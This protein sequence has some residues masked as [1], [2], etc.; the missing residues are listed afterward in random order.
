MDPQKAR[1]WRPEPSIMDY[2]TRDAVI[3]ALGLGCNV[4]DDLQYLYEN[5][6]D[7][8]VF[9]T[10]VVRPGL[11]SISLDG[12]PGIAFDLQNILH[13]EQYIELINPIP[14]DGQFRTEV[15]IV[16]ILDKGNSAVIV[17]NATTYDNKTNQKL[18]VQQ[19][20][21]FQVG[22]GK[23]GGNRTNPG[24]KTAVP[25]PKRTPDKVLELQT[26]VDQ[27][28]LYRHGSGD[29]N[30]LHIDKQ[31][32]KVAGFKQPILHG[33]CTMGVSTRAVL[34][35]Y[36]NND[37]N[38]FKA[39]KVRFSAPVV[40]GQTLKVEM[41][42]EGNRIHFQTKVK[43]TDKIV[44]S[45]AYIDLKSAS[46]T[47]SSE[48]ISASSEELVS[49]AIFAQINEQLPHQQ[50]ICKKINSIVLYDI[51]KNGKHAAYYTLDLKTGP[52]GKAFKG[53]PKEK[54]AVTVIVDDQDFLKVVTGELSGMK[55][56]MSG[57]LKARG[58]VLVLQKLQGVLSGATQSKL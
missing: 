14:D 21:T 7:F 48:V 26:T 51:T 47:A 58:N 53:E 35:A 50:G 19:F 44:I 46:A 10:F 3:Y 33:L 6:Q 36:G 27:A 13:G 45:S 9:P 11:T 4:K 16:D 41:W 20:G 25:V 23:F 1:Q 30:P 42:K 57:K 24:E 2:S 22:S 56:F 37:G 31:F 52:E 15:Q 12:A 18:A 5:H 54:P 40:P 39:I 34:K 29:M 17:T 32:A 43:E 55:A 8:Q 38:N 28:A 49:D